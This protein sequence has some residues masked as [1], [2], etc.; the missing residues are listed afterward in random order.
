ML[1]SGSKVWRSAVVGFIAASSPDRLEIGYRI[2]PSFT[3]RG[4]ATSAVRLLTDA[5][6]G[7]EG[8]T[9]AEIHHDAS[10]GVPR[11]VG[12]RLVGE[13]P[14]DVAA[15]AEIGIERIWRIDRDEWMQRAA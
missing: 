7:I 4:I 3:G 5:A 15:H 12:Y 6:L 11:R 14:D 9:H 13:T 1:A 10:A 2:H 8:I